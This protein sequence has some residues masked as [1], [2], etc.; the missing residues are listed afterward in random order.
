MVYKVRRVSKGSLDFKEQREIKGTQGR[1]VSL[2]VKGAPENRALPESRGR[3]DSKA[4]PGNRAKQ[5]TP[6]SQETKAHKET[7]VTKA[8][9]VLV[10]YKVRQANKASLDLSDRKE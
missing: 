6:A 4:P 10:E 9:R 1:K 2:V 5:G 3:P 8:S 7:P